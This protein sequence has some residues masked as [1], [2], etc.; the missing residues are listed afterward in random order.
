[1]DSDNTIENL[2]NKERCFSA[3][4][5]PLLQNEPAP[6]FVFNSSILGC[7][8]MR[9]QKNQCVITRNPGVILLRF[10]R[11]I[12]KELESSIPCLQGRQVSIKPKTNKKRRDFISSPANPYQCLITSIYVLTFSFLLSSYCRSTALMFSMLLFG[13]MQ[14]PERFCYTL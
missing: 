14:K 1:M 4:K 2:Q 12:Q 9:T 7:H 10:L 5:I 6:N 11:I 8:R 13:E 3:S